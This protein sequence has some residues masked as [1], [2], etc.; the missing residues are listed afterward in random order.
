MRQFAIFYSRPHNETTIFTFKLLLYF[1]SLY[2]PQL[3]KIITKQITKVLHSIY[4]LKQKKKKHSS[5]IALLSP[6]YP[7]A[8]RTRDA[9]LRFLESFC[10]FHEK[11]PHTREKER[12]AHTHSSRRRA[13]IGVLFGSKDGND[14]ALRYTIYSST[15]IYLF[16]A[17]VISHTRLCYYSHIFRGIAGGIYNI[18]TRKYSHPPFAR[19]VYILH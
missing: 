15:T 9:I 3:H 13:L 6:Q 1:K 12:A 17:H 19:I 2:F 7:R 14:Y 5:Y 10:R 4:K 11:L 18:A 16:H 8:L